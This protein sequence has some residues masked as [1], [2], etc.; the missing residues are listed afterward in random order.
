MARRKRRKKRGSSRFP[1]FVLVLLAAAVAGLVVVS[2]RRDSGS[3]SS[4]DSADASTE[5]SLPSGS[6]GTEPVSSSIASVAPPVTI[7]DDPIGDVVDGAVIDDFTTVDPPT[8]PTKSMPLSSTWIKN[9]RITSRLP[10]GQYWASLAGSSD[11]PERVVTFD[12][13]QVF[14]G[15]ESCRTRFGDSGEACS[16]DYGVDRKVTGRLDVVVADLLFVSLATSADPSTGQPVN[17]SISPATWWSLVNSG[18]TVVPIPDDSLDQPTD[19]FVDMPYLLTVRD[20]VVVG[21][22]VVRVP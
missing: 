17:C 14:W 2:A 6:A 18:Q 11:E 19:A 5:T 4:P 20:G 21:A 10:D 3:T 1:T 9:G 13:A 15:I 12:V 7:G 16:D 8:V 22:E